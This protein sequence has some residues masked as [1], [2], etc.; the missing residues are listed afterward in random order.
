M[1][2]LL[3]LPE[4]IG[5]KIYCMWRDAKDFFDNEAD[6]IAAYQFENDR[7]RAEEIPE[8]QFNEAYWDCNGWHQLAES[9]L[10]LC[11][12]LDFPPEYA[13][14]LA[15]QH[16]SKDPTSTGE[17]QNT[18]QASHKNLL[19]ARWENREVAVLRTAA[20]SKSDSPSTTGPSH[21]TGLPLS[22]AIL[23][24]YKKSHPNL[25]SAQFP[26]A[27]KSNSPSKATN[28]KAVSSPPV[29]AS[30]GSK[31]SQDKFGKAFLHLIR[32]TKEESPT[33]PRVTN[34]D[35][36]YE[37]LFPLGTCL[38]T[39]SQHG[40]SNN[41]PYVYP[42]LINLADD[43]QRAY[44]TLR[45]FMEATLF[46]QETQDRKLMRGPN[47]TIEVKGLIVTFDHEEDRIT[48]SNIGANLLKVVNALVLLANTLARRPWNNNAKETYQY[49][50]DFRVGTDYTRT[51]PQRRHLGETICPDD[52]VWYMER[53]FK[54]MPFE[55]IVNDQDIMAGMYQTIKEGNALVAIARPEFMPHGNGNQTDGLPTFLA[56]P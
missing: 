54:P 25:T 11:Q 13:P 1:Q 18:E 17:F 43:A 42:L 31:P 28:T 48:E 7:E 33:K 19:Q 16:L 21:K 22:Q 23:L 38:I 49:R 41:H 3:H 6:E 34:V 30:A 4:D 52:S 47:S 55:E 32:K 27:P 14:P 29:K 35:V 36:D 53:L 45:I 8:D 10:S 50:N 24:L 5:N 37:V 20:S 2:P 12:K 9:H 44:Q 40:R 56:A 46:C 15:Y 26:M 51:Q 39:F